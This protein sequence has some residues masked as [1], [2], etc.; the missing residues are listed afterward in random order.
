MGYLGL[1]FGGVPLNSWEDDK[2]DLEHGIKTFSAYPEQNSLAV[3]EE[4]YDDNWCVACILKV[5]LIWPVPLTWTMFCR[6]R[7]PCVR[8]H[9]RRLDSTR[10]IVVPHNGQLK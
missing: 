3:L 8:L 4:W 7:T 9:V 10:D 6:C 5:S 2:L 1:P